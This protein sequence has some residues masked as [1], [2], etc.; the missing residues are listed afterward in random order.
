MPLTRTPLVALSLLASFLLARDG[1]AQQ[2]P[3]TRPAA[4][5]ELTEDE[6]SYALSNGT[7]SIRV[8]KQSGDL[9]SM[10]YKGR[11]TL[12]DRSGHPFVY[13]SHDV[14]GGQSIE[15]RITIDPSTNNGERAEVSVKGI[16]GGKPMGFGPGAPPEGDVAVDIDIRYSLARDDSAV[17]AYC[18]FEHQP[19]YPAGDFTEARLAAKLDSAFTHIHV[20]PL[21]SGKY[22]LLPEFPADP[23]GADKYI[24]ATTQFDHRAYGATNPQDK[25]GWWMLIPSPEYLSA[26]PNQPDFLAHGNIVVFCYWRSSHYGHAQ[27]IL[28]QDEPWR[29]VIGPIV[30]YVNEAE[31]PEAMWEDAKARLKREEAAWPYA[32]VQGGDYAHKADRAAVTG[33]VVLRDPAAPVEGLLPGRLTVGLTK[34]PYTVKQGEQTRE[35]DWQHDA[36]H[37]QYWVRS[38][39][40]TGGFT[41]PN[42][43]PGQYNLHAFAEGILGELFKADVEVSSGGA[44][45][46]GEIDWT[47]VRAGRTVWEIGRPDRDAMEFAGTDTF[48]HPGAPLRYVKQFPQGEHIRFTV[49]ESDASKEWFYAHMPFVDDPAAQIRPFRGVSGKTKPSSRTVVFNLDTVPA[50]QATLRIAVTGSGG[51]P[52]LGVKVNDASIEPMDFGA[53]DGAIVRHQTRGD[54][55]DRAR[56]F[57]ASLLRQGENTITLTVD[58]PDPSSGVIYDCLR[59]ELAE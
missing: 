26:G 23:Q 49:G 56:S 34:T 42:V 24:Y 28:E 37:Y 18:I 25:L 16:S 22:P 17:Y 4:A 43:P 27:V 53:N 35:I 41:I 59:L 31:T 40:R 44:V 58:A 13:W 33:R 36:K 46:L 2:T 47:P 5:V 19:G 15:T 29:K 10:R 45:D 51:S 21:R 6:T 50:G 12:T 20:D 8:S 7:L 54:Y 38:D 1:S 3:P 30:M 39:D 9:I 55:R 11:E 57:D 14:K 48:W 32:W 52:V